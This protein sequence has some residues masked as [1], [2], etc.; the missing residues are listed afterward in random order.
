MG[1]LKP[2]PKLEALPETAGAGGWRA[3]AA[4]QARGTAGPQPKPS[5]HASIMHE[6]WVL[7]K[8]A[9][10]PTSPLHGVRQ[11]EECSALANLSFP[12]VFP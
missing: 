6:G 11:T 4:L 9:G 2:E 12:S 5:T 7:T 1:V 10:T 3:A 8:Q